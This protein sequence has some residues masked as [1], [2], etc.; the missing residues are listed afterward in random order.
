M[1]R[2]ALLGVMV[3]IEGLVLTANRRTF[4]PVH[5]TDSRPASDNMLFASQFWSPRQSQSTCIQKMA[6]SK[7]ESHGLR[8]Y[9]RLIT[10]SL[11]CNTCETHEQ[12]AREST[13]LVDCV[14]SKVFRVLT[15]CISHDYILFRGETRIG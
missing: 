13:S 11:S 1:L 4:M 5:T 3:W 10:C 9:R 14:V 2:S 7:A 6:T 8:G 15:G 12:F